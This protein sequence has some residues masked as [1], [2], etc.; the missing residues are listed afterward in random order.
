MIRKN[1]LSVLK[2]CAATYGIDPESQD[3][4][5]QLVRR[6]CSAIN[7]HFPY[8]KSATFWPELLLVEERTY[9]APYSTTTTYNTGDRIYF[10]DG[11]YYDAR[12]D[13]ILDESP[14]DSPTYWTEATPDR[15]IELD[16]L[17][18]TNRIGVVKDVFDSDP[19][20]S[21][22]VKRLVFE[23]D[24]DGLHFNSSV[25]KSVFVKFIAQA[26]DWTSSAYSAST[27]YGRGD[28]VYVGGEN[29]R[30][31]KTTLGI[32]TTSTTNWVLQNYPAFLVPVTARFARAEMLRDDG[33]ITKAEQEEQ[34]AEQ[35][36]SLLMDRT[37]LLQKQVASAEY[38][39]TY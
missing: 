38:V 31:L 11:I 35:A 29:Y 16:Q 6:I 17:W 33:Q 1:F 22:T 24:A 4:S 37:R 25:G 32:D 27:T 9:A 30:A 12:F 3:Y 39:S 28:V 26:E 7:Q 10:T 14:S 8:I 21:N 18:E 20:T 5:S 36:V 34:R 19:R 15:T 23:V 13:G 2:E